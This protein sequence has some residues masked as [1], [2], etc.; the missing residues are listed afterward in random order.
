MSIFIS[1]CSFISSSVSVITGFKQ[2]NSKLVTMLQPNKGVKLKDSDR[3]RLVSVHRRL[4]SMIQPLNFCVVWSKDR[5]SCIAPTVAYAL[6]LIQS[7]TDF[8]DKVKFVT[9]DLDPFVRVLDSDGSE[10]LDHYL[11]ELDFCVNSIGLCVSIAR[12]EGTI[13]SSSSSRFISPSALLKASR[14]IADMTNR[15]GDLVV[16][17]GSLFRR[18]ENETWKIV[19]DDFTLKVSQ[20]RCVDPCDVPFLIRLSSNTCSDWNVNFPIHSALSMQISTIRETQLPISIVVDDCVI[21]WKYASENDENVSPLKRRVLHRNPSGEIDNDL[22]R[23]S[24]DSEDDEALIVHG[25]ADIPSRL[26]PRISST[27]IGGSEVSAH[28]AF[29]PSGPTSLTNF[30]YTARLCVLEAAKSYI[31]TNA[32]SEPLSSSTPRSVSG[33]PFHL[34]ATDET[35]IALLADATELTQESNKE[36]A[37]GDVHSNSDESEV[38]VRLVVEDV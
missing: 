1:T 14:V 23:L 2:I 22:T 26:R 3:R 38:T 15:T 10:K 8:L 30:I 19:G 33:N 18:D 16:A 4:E 34:D 12:G 24:L 5:N 25:P 20:L 29:R 31:P 32:I 36:Q 17:K 35:L 9:D 11:R 37:L 27:H 13:N 6:D 7:V 28:Y 21:V